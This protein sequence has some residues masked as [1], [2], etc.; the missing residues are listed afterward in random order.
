MVVFRLH[1][2]ENNQAFEVPSEKQILEF[3]A[4]QDLEGLT[5]ESK[6]GEVIQLS[7]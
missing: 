6:G 4:G 3:E 7:D 2:Q 1:G 5:V